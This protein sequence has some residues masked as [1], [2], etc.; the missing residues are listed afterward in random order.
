[1]N[2]FSIKPGE[3]VAVASKA[4]LLSGHLARAVEPEPAGLVAVE[5][6]VLV[7][8]EPASELGVASALV[9]PEGV[10]TA[11]ELAVPSAELAGRGPA[12]LPVAAK[13]AVLPVLATAVLREPAAALAVGAAQTAG[14]VVQ[15]RPVLALVQ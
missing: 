5:G 9:V 1:M 15:V 2:R 8:R 3:L 12:V 10:R 13:V 6:P 14:P 11:A 4:E 7:G